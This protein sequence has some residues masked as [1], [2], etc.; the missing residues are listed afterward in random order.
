MKLIILI[1]ALGFAASVTAQIAGNCFY[2]LTE[3]KSYCA[4]DGNVS[5]TLLAG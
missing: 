4:M 5:F 1:N 2:S 3:Q